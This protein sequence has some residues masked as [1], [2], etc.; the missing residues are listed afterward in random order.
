MTDAPPPGFYP[1]PEDPARQ[2]WWDGTAWA[3]PDASQPATTVDPHAAF[4]V[5][6]IMAGLMMRLLIAGVV[7]LIVAATM[8][9]FTAP[10]V[11]AQFKETVDAINAGREPRAVGSDASAASTI[12]QLA[13]LG[14]LVVGV[15]FVV[16]SYRAARMARALRFRESWAPG[17]A[18]GGWFI[19]LANFVI[20]YFVVRGLF[21]PEDPRRPLVGRW[22]SAYVAMTIA[23]ALVSIVPILTD[24]PSAFLT[25]CVL[26]YSVLVISAGLAARAVVAAVLAA[27]AETLGVAIDHSPNE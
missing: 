14:Y 13:N 21:A 19:P 24:V 17:W 12:G 22:W 4:E 7:L 26:A 11:R 23:G 27:H 18:I 25:A 5:E 16:W 6:R 8:S 3:S 15:G 9:I 1:D 2:R 20:P 10:S